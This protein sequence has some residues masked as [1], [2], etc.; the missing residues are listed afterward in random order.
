M[1]PLTIRV[2]ATRTASLCAWGPALPL[3]AH[4]ARSENLIA[5]LELPQREGTSQTEHSGH[6]GDEPYGVAFSSGTAATAAVINTLVG[7]GNHLVSVGDVVRS[8]SLLPSFTY[9]PQYGGTNR[10]FTK[11]ASTHGIS[12]TFVDMSARPTASKSDEA[13]EQDRL[14]RTISNAFQ[15]HTKMVWIESVCASTRT[16]PGAEHV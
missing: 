6:P 10:Y 15:G 12:V 2:L 1:Q 5:S 13:A 14:V 8:L 9:A 3:R 16:R 7:S 4:A 11:V